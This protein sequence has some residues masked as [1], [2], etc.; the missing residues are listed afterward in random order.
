MASLT[1][2]ETLGMGTDL[3]GTQITA[4]A[5]INTLGSPTAIGTSSGAAAYIVCYITN[6]SV[7]VSY[8]IDIGADEA[9]GT[10]Y[11]YFAKEIPVVGANSAT[12]GLGLFVSIPLPIA[13]ASGTQFAARCQ[14]DTTAETVDVHIVVYSGT[15]DFTVAWVESFGSDTSTSR[16]QS[17]DPGAT[18]TTKG[19]WVELV[20]SASGDVD[21]LIPIVTEQPAQTVNSNA[22]MV[23]DIGTG[24]AASEVVKAGDLG[25]IEMFSENRSSALTAIEVLISSGDRVAARLQSENTTSGR[26]EADVAVVAFKKTSTAGG[27]GGLIVHPGM[28]GGFNG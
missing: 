26:R 3:S 25:V 13:F 9:G 12:S 10:S 28:T 11:T 18:A 19:A 15:V 20:A 24:S 22:R 6:Y 14:S 23:L 4:H 27:S 7:G 1:W 17:L 16:G 8:L 2:L 21:Y 5:T